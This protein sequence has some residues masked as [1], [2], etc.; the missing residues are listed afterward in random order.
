[1]DQA[2]FKE[3]VEN[4]VKLPKKYKVVMYNDDYTP[5]EIVVFILVEIF[6]KLLEEAIALALAIHQSGKS[7]IGTY[8]YDI[9]NTKLSQAQEIVDIEGVPLKMELIEEDI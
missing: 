3:E 7:V 2:I 5:M 4:K 9:A 6:D 8:S 1:M